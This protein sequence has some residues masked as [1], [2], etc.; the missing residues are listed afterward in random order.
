MGRM[1]QRAFSLIELLIVL[2]ILGAAGAFVAPNLW[3]SLQKSS[4]RSAVYDYAHELLALRRD[5]YQDGRGF[6]I[7]E[8]QLVRTSSVPGLPAVPAGWQIASQTSLSFLPNGVCSGGEL[9]FESP[10][11]RRWRLQFAALD[12]RLSVELL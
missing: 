11:Q 4:E 7:E 12:A 8:N 6:N 1:R 10:S 5:L 3:Q 2:A 9:V